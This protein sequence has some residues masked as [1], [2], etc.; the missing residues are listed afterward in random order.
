MQGVLSRDADISCAALQMLE[1]HRFESK[2]TMC[3]TLQKE[4]NR[5]FRALPERGQIERLLPIV[6]KCAVVGRAPN[7]FGLGLGSEIDRSGRVF[8]T[9]RFQ[10]AKAGKPYSTDDF[11]TRTDVDIMNAWML[12]TNR[13]KPY[14]RMHPSNCSYHG[15]TTQLEL[16]NPAASSF[17]TEYLGCMDNRSHYGQSR[18]DQPTWVLHPN[19]SQTAAWLLN[20][21]MPSAGK[22]AGRQAGRRKQEIFPSHGFTAVVFALTVCRKV[23]LYG[24]EEERRGHNKKLPSPAS[25]YGD[26]VAQSVWEGH[27]LHREHASLRMLAHPDDS[28]TPSAVRQWMGRMQHR[29]V[30][31]YE[32]AATTTAK[33]LPTPTRRRRDNLNTTTYHD[34]T[35]SR[36]PKIY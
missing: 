23:H 25:S 5:L 27:E 36:L 18:S 3:N 22:Q 17:L 16:Y 26:N 33:A 2:T 30:L 10:A 14:L 19:V 13:D 9:N 1:H 21:C 8:R 6:K 34:T 31:F 12:T 4:K 15:R 35:R 32:R 24:F 11:G 7:L 29:P 20:T 28:S